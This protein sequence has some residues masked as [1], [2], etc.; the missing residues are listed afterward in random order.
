MMQVD[1]VGVLC[2]VVIVLCF[3]TVEFVLPAIAAD[4]HRAERKRLR[5]HLEDE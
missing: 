2:G 5:G 1:W 4:F 3:L